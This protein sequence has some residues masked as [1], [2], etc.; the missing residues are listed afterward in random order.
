MFNFF[1]I[2]AYIFCTYGLTLIFTQSIGPFNIFYIIRTWAKRISDNLGMLFTCPLCF[3]TNIGWVLSVINW[4]L[5]PINITPFNII[6]E[7][8]N[9]WWIA[10]LLD[11]C[12][13]GAT[14][15]IIYNIDDYIDKSTPYF[16]DMEE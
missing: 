1:V 11:A 16:E 4:F 6:L 3:G 9:L 7:G 14:C 15:K 13:T 2:F 8:T 10:L 5:I 12:F